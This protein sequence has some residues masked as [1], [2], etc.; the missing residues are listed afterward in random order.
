MNI[1]FTRKVE[2][3]MEPENTPGRGTIIDICKQISE[4]KKEQQNRTEGKR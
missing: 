3:H 2:G 4:H 1:F